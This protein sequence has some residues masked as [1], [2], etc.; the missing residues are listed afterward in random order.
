M[1]R[2]L[3]YGESA[4]LVPQP[5]G[6]GTCRAVH[7]LRLCSGTA[8]TRKPTCRTAALPHRPRRRQ[9]RGGAPSRANPPRRV[10]A[11]TGTRLPAARRTARVAPAERQ[12][13]AADVLQEGAVRAAAQLPGH[14]RAQVPPAA[15]HHHLRRAPVS[16]TLTPNPDTNTCRRSPPRLDPCQPYPNL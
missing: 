6:V 11:S 3:K 16:P 15:R 12:V 14:L 5:A 10:R 13:L 1:H 7:S 8:P 9:A 2:G 4:L